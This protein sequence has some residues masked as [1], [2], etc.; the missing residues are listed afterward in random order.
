MDVA[1]SFEVIPP[2]V[3]SWK[4]DSCDVGRV[5]IAG[6]FSSWCP[7]AMVRSS[8]GMWTISLE[9]S[10]GRHEYKVLVDGDWRIDDSVPNIPNDMGSS[11]NI[12]E[13]INPVLIT[14]QYRAGVGMET[15]K[16][17]NQVRKSLDRSPTRSGKRPSLS[18]KSDTKATSIG[19]KTE[20]PT[21]HLEENP[22]LMSPVTRGRL[23]RVTAGGVKMSCGMNI[24]A[25]SQSVNPHSAH[26]QVMAAKLA[27]EGKVQ[28]SK[29]SVAN[30]GRAPTQKGA[31][32]N[33]GRFQAT[34]SKVVN[35]VRSQPSKAS[36]MNNGKSL[37]Q[38]GSSVNVDR[39]QQPKGSMENGKRPVASTSSM[40]GVLKPKNQENKARSQ[41]IPRTTRPVPAAGRTATTK[42]QVTRRSLDR[43]PTRSGKRSSFSTKSD[44]N[45][46]PV[47]KAANQL[48]MHAPTVPR[49]GR[50]SSTKSIDG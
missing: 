2:T 12:L 4:E 11:N 15:S 3:L 18:K 31:A 22:L 24:G 1:K 44:E 32:V 5:E 8:S 37:P 36:L 35:N 46:C 39:L 28:P 26:T 50:R 43:S 38:K 48:G 40:V 34:K 33:N 25:K 27:K 49:T 19:P 7:L 41:P 30:G 14:H 21:C 29:S 13:V 16:V 45:T 17:E 20:R 42:A 47:A 9:L 23:A 6:S 10:P